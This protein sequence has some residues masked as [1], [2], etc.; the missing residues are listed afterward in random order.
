[1]AVPVLHPGFLLCLLR[2]LLVGNHKNN[3]TDT[4]RHR[5]RHRHR[6]IGPPFVSDPL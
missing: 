1:M 4:H 2:G 3:T 5:H 6:H